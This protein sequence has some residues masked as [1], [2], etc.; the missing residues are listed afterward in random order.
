MSPAQADPRGHPA[1][2]VDY[3]CSPL[4]EDD[5]A[6]FTWAECRRCDALGRRA[7]MSEFDELVASQVS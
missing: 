4:A 1:L 6:P 3:R 7:E 2:V 5:S